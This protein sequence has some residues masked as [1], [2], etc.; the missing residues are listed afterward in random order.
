M[1]LT[2][3]G[4]ILGRAGSGASSAGPEFQK[5]QVCQHQGD[6]KPPE[7]VSQFLADR[8]DRNNEAQKTCDEDHNLQCS[9]GVDL[10]VLF[11]SK[12]L[13]V[14]QEPDGFPDTSEPGLFLLG[15]RNPD[16]ET[17]SLSLWDAEEERTC[18]L[19]FLQSIAKGFWH[20]ARCCRSG[21]VRPPAQFL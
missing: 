4:D 12:F 5:N 6:A 10:S 19:V 2:E 1:P 17:A 20:T 11:Q 18:F 9:H 7:N 14:P 8:G 13:P 21:S 16:A 3:I 15:D